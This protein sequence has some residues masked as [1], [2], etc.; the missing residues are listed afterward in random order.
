MDTD[1]GVRVYFVGQIGNQLFHYCLGKILAEKYELAF[2]PP[3]YFVDKNGSPV[4]W[5]GEPLFV[6]QP[7]AG[8]RYREELPP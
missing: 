1:F 7:T 5:S 4:K 8:R 2:D 6:M 3:S